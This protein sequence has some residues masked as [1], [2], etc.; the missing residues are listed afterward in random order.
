MSDYSHVEE[1]WEGEK[2]KKSKELMLV[3]TR[4]AELNIGHE[5]GLR[6]A[7]AREV[8]AAILAGTVG[9][10]VMQVPLGAAGVVA[11]NLD[12]R[13]SCP[14]LVDLVTPA[15]SPCASLQLLDDLEDVMIDII[16]DEGEEHNDADSGEDQGG[17]EDRSRWD[18]LSF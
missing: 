11:E 18:S 4:S 6:V 3:S 8:A 15:P 13:G 9:G 1:D 17:D 7:V 2:E 10:P 5:E 16:G 12:T 14:E